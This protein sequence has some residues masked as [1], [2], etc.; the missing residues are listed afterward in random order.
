MHDPWVAFANKAIAGHG[1]WYSWLE[2]EFGW[3]DDTALN[4]MRVH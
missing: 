2:R 1:N 4:F 3:T